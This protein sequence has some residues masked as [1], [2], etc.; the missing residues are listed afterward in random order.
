MQPELSSSALI[1]LDKPMGISSAQA[2]AQV[3]R[4]LKIAKIGHAGTLDPMASGLLVCLLNAATRLA[5][6]AEAGRKRYRGT[7]RL[8]LTTSSDDVTGEVLSTS[9]AL[10]EFLSVEALAQTFVGELDQV[11]PQVSAVKVDGQRSYARVRAGETV[12]L[13]A[14]RVQLYSLHLAPISSNQIEFVM[15]SSPG[16]YVRSLARDL[17]EK[18]GCGGCLE[19]LRREASYPFD[20]KDAKCLDELSEADLIGVERLFPQTARLV[21]PTRDAQDLLRGEQ[22]WLEQLLQRR[23]VQ[24]DQGSVVYYDEQRPQLPLGLLVREG[25]R[26]KIG[27]NLAG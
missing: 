25:E 21:L 18:L 14:R 12:A 6:F 5:Q 9:D 1:L 8:G 16:F 4:R 19:T 22:R 2:I 17:G 11:P 24:T 20:V 10:P 23:G 3:K 15:E 27:V 7:I 13:N 26:W